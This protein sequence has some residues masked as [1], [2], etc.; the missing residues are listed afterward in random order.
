MT[1]RGR[2]FQTKDYCKLDRKG[3]ALWCERRA[4]KSNKKIALLQN[5]RPK[6]TPMIIKKKPVWETLRREDSGGICNRYLK[7][8]GIGICPELL[9]V[10]GSMVIN[11]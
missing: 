11:K 9:S 6:R 1:A 5:F 3:D 7:Q 10:P 8:I 4:V 2:C